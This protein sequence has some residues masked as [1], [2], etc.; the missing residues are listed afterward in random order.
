MNFISILLTLIFP[1]GGQILFRREIQGL[2]LAVLF[3]TFLTLSILVRS[4]V[5]WLPVSATTLGLSAAIIWLFAQFDVS[6][7]VFRRKSAHWQSHRDAAFTRGFNALLKKNFEEAEI[8]MRETLQ[9]DPADADAWHYLKFIYEKQGRIRAAQK[10]DRQC[11][12]FDVKGKW[13]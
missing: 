1:G 9:T 7:M 12:Y 3:Y 8:S 13:S 4:N 11:R 10:A 2:M 6:R 5:L